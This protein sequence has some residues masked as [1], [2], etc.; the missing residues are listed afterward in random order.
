MRPVHFAAARRT[1]IGKLRGALSCVRPDD[2][3]AD[4]RSAACSPSVPA[5][6][7]ARDRRRLLGRRQPG[8][9]GQPQRRP[10]GRAA[11]RAARVAC[12][13]P[14]STGCAPPAWRPSPPPPAPSPRARPT[15][16]VAGGSESMSRAPFVL[17]RPDEALP[18][19]DRDRRHPARLAAGQPADEGTARRCWPW[20]RPPRRSPPGTGHAASGR[21]SSRCAATGWPPRPARTATSTPRCCRCSA[22]TAWSS[23]PT[24]ASARTPS[25]EKLA[26]LKPVFRAGRHGHRG[27]RLAD[28]R[29]RGRHCS[30]SARRRCNELGLESLGRYV[31]GASRRRPPRRDG[32]RPGPRHPQ[33]ARPAPAGASATSR[34]PSSTRRSPRRR[35]PAWTS[36]ASTPSWSTRPAARS[37]SAIRWAA[38]AP[39]SSPR[40]CTACAAPARTRGLA[41]MCVGVGQGSAVLVEC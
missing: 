7:P 31:A 19:R 40:C 28:E 4:R 17:P 38:P 29:R 6:D 9:R 37:R 41:T 26:R 3:A 10:D 39:A 36:S 2:L 21:T 13:A 15:S 23:T 18:H 25:Y 8:R 33:G 12:P 32:H 1:P 34:R 35:S 16:C 20:A 11:R 14:P 22:R 27:Q 30:W 24:R 5:L